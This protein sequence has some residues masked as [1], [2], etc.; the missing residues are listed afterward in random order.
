MTLNNIHYN[1]VFLLFLTPYFL[2]KYVRMGKPRDFGKVK[3][4][5]SNNALKKSQKPAG[6]WDFI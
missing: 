2:A 3:T 1:N 4:Y 6:L 5:Q